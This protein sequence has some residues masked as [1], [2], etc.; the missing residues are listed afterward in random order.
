MSRP[1]HMLDDWSSIPCAGNFFLF[2]TSRSIRPRIQQVPNE[3]DEW[4]WS[5]LPPC[6]NEESN[7]Q[8]E[9]DAET[10]ETAWRCNTTSSYR[11][12]QVTKMRVLLIRPALKLLS[13]S[14]PGPRPVVKRLTVLCCL[15]RRQPSGTRWVGLASCVP[16]HSHI[17]HSTCWTFPRSESGV[18]GSVLFQGIVICDRTIP[19]W[20]NPTS[21]QKVTYLRINFVSEQTGLPQV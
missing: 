10:S 19:R 17:L 1:G 14:G 13:C 16:T 18:A 12:K 6:L 15:D 21:Y 20:R 2:T 9:A 7:Q 3:V 5:F 11:L 8:C 4:I